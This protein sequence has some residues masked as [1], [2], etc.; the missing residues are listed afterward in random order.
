MGSFLE[1]NKK[2]KLGFFLFLNKPVI[3]TVSQN[4][5][6]YLLKSKQ[7]AFRFIFT[8]ISFFVQVRGIPI[9]ALN[10]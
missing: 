1:I 5:P 8:T 10:V 9:D 4:Y 7:R 3:S 6:C 2:K